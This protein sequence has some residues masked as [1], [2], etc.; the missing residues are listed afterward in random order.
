MEGLDFPRNKIEVEQQYIDS[1]H[2]SAPQ[3]L[4]AG[5]AIIVFILG[6]LFGG[7]YLFMAV[8]NLINK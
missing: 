1:Y 5:I 7:A 4:V 2:Y 3:K 8:F 6:L